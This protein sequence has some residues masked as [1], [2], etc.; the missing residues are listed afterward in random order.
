MAFARH[1][2]S[3]ISTLD[4]LTNIR[5]F[6]FR[7]EALAAIASVAFVKIR[8]CSRLGGGERTETGGQ[9]S[10]LSGVKCQLP[11]EGYEVIYKGGV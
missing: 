5:S 6:G 7:G 11:Q 8:S 2:T 3:K 1:A 4:D 9:L 10:P